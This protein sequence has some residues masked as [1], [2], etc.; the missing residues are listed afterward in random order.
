MSVDEL[1]TPGAPA[2]T[3]PAPD[4]LAS[5]TA[6]MHRL[7]RT[8]LA[9]VAVIIIVVGVFVAVVMNRGEISHASLHSATAALP[10]IAPADPAATPKLVWKTTDKIAIG[11]PTYG[12]TVITY[13]AH[14]VSARNALTGAIV[15]TYTRTDMTVCQVVQETG[16]TVAF[17]DHNGNCD[18]VDAFTTGTGV[19]T[20]YRTLD[21]DTRAING[22]PTFSVDQYSIV[23]STPALV[24]SITPSNGGDHWYFVEPSGCTT[25]GTAVV[26]SQGVL[27][28]Q[29]CGD[30]N[31]LLLRDVYAGED[32]KPDPIKWRLKDVDAVP[33]AAGDVICA[34][35]RAT[36]SLVAY[37][38][39]D[40]VVLGDIALSGG[41]D[42][43]PTAIA[44]STSTTDLYLTVDGTGYDISPVTRT[45]LWSTPTT[46]PMEFTT[47]RI[48]TTTAA[49]VAQLDL[50][51]GAAAQTY[52][53][54][55][56]ASGGVVY[57]IGSALIVG[58][59]STAVYR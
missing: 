47:G 6:R 3:S 38:L 21:S 55:T 14:T 58:G 20:W 49:G 52:A 35:D 10:S 51:S 2:A 27:I 16:N 36:G 32:T 57:P 28:A 11:S 43:D 33:V 37:R 1:P 18:E 17:F 13:G 44:T 34:F 53:L 54:P 41:P 39:A 15:W 46:G 25:K 12:G 8:Y 59:D 30:G 22:R 23:L 29:Q 4:A 19:R 42:R 26:G 48:Y 5:Y 31:H 24:Q 56:P 7:R 40:G 9:V 50:S 45:Q